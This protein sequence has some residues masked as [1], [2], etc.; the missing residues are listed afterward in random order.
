MGSPE[1]FANQ[2]LIDGIVGRDGMTQAQRDEKEALEQKRDQERKA[3][4]FIQT[5]TGPSYFIRP[6]RL[7]D[8]AHV[9]NLDPLEVFEM[10][11]A[12][13]RQIVEAAQTDLEQTEQYRDILKV[14]LD[15]R[16]LDAE[17]A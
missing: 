16:A 5:V 14:Q 13:K 6:D 11:L 12:A 3:Q 9:H 7:V 17:S 1:S 2:L 10:V 15:Q 8:E 4:A